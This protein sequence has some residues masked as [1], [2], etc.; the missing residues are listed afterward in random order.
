[1]SWQIF[2]VQAAGYERWYAMRRARRVDKAES[3]LLA[4]LLEPFRD[5][6]TALEVGCGTGHFTQRLQAQGLIAA[7]LDRSPAMLN[8]ARSRFPLIPFILGDA[9]AL[10][11]HERSVDMVVFI[12]ALEFLQDAMRAGCEAVRVA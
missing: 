10:P 1:M 5:M 11:F 3:A 2:E 4:Y 7:G 9:Y 6:R 8:E 12:A